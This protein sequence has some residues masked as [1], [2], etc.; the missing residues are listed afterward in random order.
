MEWD[1]VHK[2]QGSF[3]QAQQG[4]HGSGLFVKV[5]GGQGSGQ[6]VRDSLSTLTSE[7]AMPG[8]SVQGESDMGQPNQSKQNVRPC[9][10]LCRK[11]GRRKIYIR[12]DIGRLVNEY[13]VFN[14][15][16]QHELS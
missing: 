6:G 14:L 13:S 4:D 12:L 5:M 7:F 10:N 16:T 1:L 9:K 8:C 11:V 2:Q 3:G 15:L